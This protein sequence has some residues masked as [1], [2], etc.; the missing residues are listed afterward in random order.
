MKI[1]EII[2]IMH[3]HHKRMHNNYAFFS[4]DADSH[5]SHNSQ[6]REDSHNFDEEQDPNL[7]PYFIISHIRVPIFLSVYSADHAGEQ[8]CVILAITYAFSTQ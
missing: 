3:M 2:C 8:F 7:D 5:N 4:M 6:I 1:E